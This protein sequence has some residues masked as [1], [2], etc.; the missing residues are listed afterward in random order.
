M[1]ASQLEAVSALEGH[2]AT[3]RVSPTDPSGWVAAALDAGDVSRLLPDRPQ[4]QFLTTSETFAVVARSEDGERLAWRRNDGEGPALDSVAGMIA[5][6]FGGAPELV[7]AALLG[8]DPNINGIDFAL[9]TIVDLPGRTIRPARLGR[10]PVIGYDGTQLAFDNTARLAGPCLCVAGR[11]GWNFMV[12]AADASWSVPKILAALR[13]L[14]SHEGQPVHPFAMWKLG[15]TALL[16][17]D[18][19][20]GA[21][22]LAV[23]GPV[24]QTLGEVGRLDRE[25]ENRL[26]DALSSYAD[27]ST[28][29]SALAIVQETPGRSGIA[30]FL[31]AVGLPSQAAEILD[32]RRGDHVGAK[33]LEHVPM[34]AAKRV[35]AAPRKQQIS[36]VAYLSLGAVFMVL[37]FLDR[38]SLPGVLILVLAGTFLMG[39][40]VLWQVARAA[41]RRASASTSAANCTSQ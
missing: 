17:V 24:W 19:A 23:L 2:V 31:Q 13:S 10:A 38:D 40:A 29:R 4:I 26:I 32:M 18:W 35:L 41:R 5:S 16:R 36:A 15:D 21:A 22:A 7:A 12:P 27:P 14:S 20:E 34:K 28:V 1:R 33:R 30:E 6:T 11:D 25:R 37:G 3:G 39:G 9:R 8:T